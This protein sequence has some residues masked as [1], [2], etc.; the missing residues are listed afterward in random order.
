MTD[1]V[2]LAGAR[3]WVGLSVAVGSVATRKLQAVSESIKRAIIIKVN[4]LFLYIRILS[5]SGQSG[6]GD[7][8]KSGDL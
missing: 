3:V 8:P 6:V 7:T 2:G 5:D 4:S 1:S